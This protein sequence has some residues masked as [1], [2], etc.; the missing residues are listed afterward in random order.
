MERGAQRPLPLGVLPDR[1]LR[2]RFAFC[3]SVVASPPADEAVPVSQ[4]PAALEALTARWH[5]AHDDTRRRAVPVITATSRW[6]R[7]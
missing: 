2:W 6:W 7:C 3:R 4:R 1:S 5:I